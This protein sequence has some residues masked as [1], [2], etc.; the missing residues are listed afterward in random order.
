MSATV[1]VSWTVRRTAEAGSASTLRLNCRAN[2]R[3]IF[4]ASGSAE[5]RFLNS[6]GLTRAGPLVRPPRWLIFS[7]VFRFTMTDTVTFDLAGAAFIRTAV[8][9]AAFSLPGRTT[10]CSA[11]FGSLEEIDLELGGFAMIDHFLVLAS[12]L[13][14]L[15]R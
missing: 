1:P 12:R 3:T 13:K 2:A 9:G 5:W 8:G 10:R 7:A 15:A 11:N 6:A 14:T 4:S